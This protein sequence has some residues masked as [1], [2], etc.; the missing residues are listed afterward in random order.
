MANQV[1]KLNTIAIANI[2]AINGLNDTAIEAING[3]EF[4]GVIPYTGIT[5]STD[6]VLPADVGAGVKMGVIG[7]T[8]ILNGSTKATYEHDGSSWSTTGSC[9]VEHQVAGG[10]GT[11]SAAWHL[12]VTTAALA[13][14]VSR[15]KNITAQLGQLETTCFKKAHLHQAAAHS[16]QRNSAQVAQITTQPSVI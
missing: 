6:D 10:G 8:A 1:E 9:S 11:Q 3:L 16:R 2:E 12:V 14:T 13:M 15:P 5:W 4:T 7:A